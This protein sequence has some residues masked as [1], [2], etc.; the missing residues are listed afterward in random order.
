MAM[1]AQFDSP[2]LA[3]LVGTIL[4]ALLNLAIA[5]TV[6]FV[7]R[8]RVRTT[9]RSVAERASPGSAA[10]LL[11]RRARRRALRTLPAG[12]ERAAGA[13][14]QRQWVAMIEDAAYT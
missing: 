14:N 6:Y 7:L 9:A 13:R 5:L 4:K 10:V 12:P 1:H 11:D 2:L 3:G 8:H